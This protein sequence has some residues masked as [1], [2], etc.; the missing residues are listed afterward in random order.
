M[1]VDICGY[2]DSLHARF[3]QTPPRRVEGGRGT[4]IG[5]PHRYAIQHCPGTEMKV[6]I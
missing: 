5:A 6:D 4:S 1:K 3:D 2:T